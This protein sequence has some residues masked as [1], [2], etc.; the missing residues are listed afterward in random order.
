M[1]SQPGFLSALGDGFIEAFG[2]RRSA[3]LYPFRSLLDHGI[4]LA[5]S[6]DAPVI[7]A[8]PWI[9]IRDARLRRTAA[10]VVLGVGQQLTASEAIRAYTSA[11]TQ[12]GVPAADVG[13]LAAGRPADFVVVDDLPDDPDA[14][15]AVSV[16]ATYVANQ[17]RYVRPATS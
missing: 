3:Y 13:V 16:M 6:S 1:V 4:Q 12:T 11:S 15:A 5:F 2:V 14:A 17:A 9:G 7:S 8:S 10:G